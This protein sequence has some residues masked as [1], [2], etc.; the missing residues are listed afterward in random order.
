MTGCW[1]RVFRNSR[2]ENVEVEYLT[3]D[4]RCT[5]FQDRTKEETLNWL[6]T[7]CDTVADCERFLLRLETAGVVKRKEQEDEGERV[8]SDGG[9]SGDR[10]G[11]GVE[12]SPQA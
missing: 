1:L 5:I 8:S 6:H 9:C 7:V 12:P 4:E 11:D 10:G 3:K 2:W